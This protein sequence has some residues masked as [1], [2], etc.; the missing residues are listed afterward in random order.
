VTGYTYPYLSYPYNLEVKELLLSGKYGVVAA[1]DGYLLLERGWPPPGISPHTPSIGIADILPNLPDAFCSF[2]HVSPKQ[3]THP[4]QV[5]FMAT[6]SS[7]AS[8][9]LIGYSVAAPNT[10][11][12]STRYMQITAYW[13]VNT[14]NPPALRLFALLI[15][16]NG[17]EEYQSN[18][19]PSITWCPTNTWKP[20]TILETTSRTLFL[21]DVP[22][23][24]AHVAIALLPLSVPFGT[25]MAVQGRLPLHIVSA[26]STITRAQN[27]NAL[28][29]ETITIAS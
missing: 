7:S 2:V 10:F 8:I 20:G 23:G 24:L 12:V 29:L 5:D 22:T 3:V 1:Q 4:L 27:S 19:F 18:D 21:G 25:M 14:P 28:Q 11:T 9:S 6:N 16:K 13:R 26:P 17:K 15:G